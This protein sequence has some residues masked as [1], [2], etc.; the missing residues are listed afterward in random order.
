MQNKR[1]KVALLALVSLG[2]CAFPAQVRHM[3]TD[4]NE[5]NARTADSL[6]LE[7]VLRARDYEPLHFTSFSALRGNVTASGTLSSSNAILGQAVARV[8][9][10]SPTTTTTDAA[11]TY[12]PGGNLMLSTQPSFDIG[13]SDSQEFYQGVTTSIPDQTIINLIQQGWRDDL[14]AFLLIKQVNVYLD[15]DYG[16]EHDQLCGTKKSASRN[17]ERCNI[18]TTLSGAAKGSLILSYENDPESLGNNFPENLNK[19]NGLPIEDG[20]Q[21]PDPVKF[22]EFVKCFALQ[23]STS[24]DKKIGL[25][26]LSQVSNI[27]MSDLSS[28]DGKTLIIAP[29]EVSGKKSSVKDP[30]ASDDSSIP[31]IAKDAIVQRVIPGKKTLIASPR[32][33]QSGDDQEC[34]RNLIKITDDEDQGDSGSD[35]T[36]QDKP[37]S[38]T[39]HIV[40]DRLTPLQLRDFDNRLGMPAENIFICQNGSDDVVHKDQFCKNIKAQ[41][42]SGWNRADFEPKVKIELVLR[43]VLGVFDGLGAYLRATEEVHDNQ[44]LNPHYVDKRYKIP[45]SDDGLRNVPIFSLTTSTKTTSVVSTRHNGQFYAAGAEDIS[46]H[47]KT[48]ETQISMQVVDLLEQLVNLQK[49]SADKPSTQAVEVVH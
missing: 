23:P 13:I 41:R 33:F 7:N 6:T 11:N 10:A 31:P 42:I 47:S 35:R 34:Q 8:V 27:R 21:T 1:R 30:K 3:A 24:P 32:D 40:L 45:V 4:F 15:E 28:F 17:R 20:D 38:F 37:I 25:V 14:L 48:D 26:K 19:V 2:G 49:N 44:K 9:G 36:Q 46:D 39:G 12:T 16:K 5:S 29:G 22:A 43:S 18:L